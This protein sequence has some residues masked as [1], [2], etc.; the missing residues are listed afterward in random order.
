[1]VGAEEVPWVDPAGLEDLVT[2]VVREGGG[3]GE[4]RG[5]GG[6]EHGCAVPLWEVRGSYPRCERVEGGEWEEEVEG[7]EDLGEGGGG[8]SILRV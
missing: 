1:M 8:V 2:V 4:V 5:E 7:G 6:E 3:G